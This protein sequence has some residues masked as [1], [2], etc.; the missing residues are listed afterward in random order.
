MIVN[1][2]FAVGSAATSEVVL[3]V[4]M[5]GWHAVSGFL[6]VAPVLVVLFNEELFP[7]VMAASAAALYGT[8]VWS[9][10]S[11]RPAAGLFY[12][13]NPTGDAVLHVITGTIFLVG[14]VLAFRG[15]DVKVS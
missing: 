2:D 5:N 9:A 3:G 14:A 1:P 10:L 15:T 6:I 7:W 12:F 11:S 4:D 13:P 8:A